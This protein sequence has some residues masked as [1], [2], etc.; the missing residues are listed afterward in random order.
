MKKIFTTLVIVTAFAAVGFAQPRAIGA[1]LGLS[2]EFSYQ[3]SITDGMYVDLTAGAGGIWGGWGS[4]DVNAS[5]DWSFNIKG[6][7]NWFIGP[8]AG[9]GYGYGYNYR[10]YTKAS[11]GYHGYHDDHYYDYPYM[12]F[13]LNIG[14]QIG[15][16]WQFN[17]PL[18]LTVDWRPTI[19]LLGFTN[20]Y[21]RHHAGWAN[22]YNIGVGVRY[23]FH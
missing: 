16:E 17:I 20:P 8:T 4:F 13:R 3:H 6:I 19:N 11:H 15:F 21:Y 23:R 10:Y 1:R 7:F 12:P 22:M 14:G 5:F 18:N 9:F 2:E